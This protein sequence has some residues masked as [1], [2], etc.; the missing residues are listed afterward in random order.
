MIT[1]PMYVYKYFTS[2]NT[3]LA[4][5]TTRMTNK[6]FNNL[7]GTTESPVDGVIDLLV[8]VITQELQ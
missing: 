3:K 4:V 6:S 8:C 2:P 5:H 1:I 7:K